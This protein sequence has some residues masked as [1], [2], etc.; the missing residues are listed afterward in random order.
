MISERNKIAE[1]YRAQGIKQSELIRNDVDKQKNILI[2]DAKAQAEKI[3]AEGES[4]YMKILSSAYNTPD[5]QAFYEF[6]RALDALEI[7][8]AGQSTIIL[9]KDSI[10]AKALTNP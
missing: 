8:L 4:E 1:E 9:G 6:T 5:K 7:S 10:I 2:S 3:K